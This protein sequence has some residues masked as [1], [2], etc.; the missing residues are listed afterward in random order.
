M[1]F[2][3]YKSG[4]VLELE[5]N[6]AKVI[7]RW[8]DYM[9]DKNINDKYKCQHSTAKRISTKIEELNDTI[10]EANEFISD[11]TEGEATIFEFSD[12]TL[13]QK[14]LNETHKKWVYLTD[15]YKNQIF[16]QPSFWHN[17]NHHVHD[18]EGMF[19]ADFRN[20]NEDK[21]WSLPPEYRTE[22]LPEDG[23]YVQND[24]V[25]SFRDL[26]RHQHNQWMLGSDIDDE[27]NNYKTVSLDFGYRHYADQG[28]DYT[29]EPP[30]PSGYVEWCK[31][32]NLSVLPP[33]IS[34][35]KFKKY[36]RYEVRK[37]FHKNLSEE[38]TLGFEL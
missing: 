23:A 1:K 6:R 31:E 36:D 34:V 18:I 12:G 29:S 19:S 16:P 8:F 13:D 27:T 4:D 2:V 10:F 15:K 28:P 38:S 33:W 11:K 21:L 3:F 20:E 17:V 5:P 24:L 22:I 37:M 30:A 25:L 7:E 35:G 14:F 32:R 9:F 26:G